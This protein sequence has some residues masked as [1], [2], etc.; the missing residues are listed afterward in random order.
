MR[1]INYLLSIIFVAMLIGAFA[2]GG[3]LN[4]FLVDSNETFQAYIEGIKY[5]VSSGNNDDL[6]GSITFIFDESIDV[7]GDIKIYRSKNSFDDAYRNGKGVTF[8]NGSE[9]SNGEYFFVAEIMTSVGGKYI[10]PKQVEIIAGE[11]VDLALSLEDSLKFSNL[12]RISI[13]D[14]PTIGYYLVGSKF[15]VDGIIATLTFD[16]MTIDVT[17]EEFQTYG[18]NTLLKD[19]NGEFTPIEIGQT[20]TENEIAKSLYLVNRD[21]SAECFVE[22]MK[23]SKDIE[24][25]GDYGAF[26]TKETSTDNLITKEAKSTFDYFWNTANSDL[27]SEGYG[28]VPSFATNTYNGTTTTTESLGFSLIS[29]IIGIENGWVDKYTAYERVAGTLSTIENLNTYLGIFYSEIDINTGKPV[30]D[31]VVSVTDSAQL[32]TCVLITGNYFGG[33]IEEKANEIYRNAKW[34]SFY[35]SEDSMFFYD[36]YTSRNGFYN[37]LE[38]YEGQLLVYILS[39]ASI[40]GSLGYNAYYTMERHLGK[41]GKY[42][43][44][45]HTWDGSLAGHLYPQAFVN[46]DGLVDQKGVNWYKNSVIATYTSKEFTDSKS[47][48]YPT[49]QI[50]WGLSA[51]DMKKGYFTNHGSTPSGYTNNIHIYDGTIPVYAALSS[52]NFYPEASVIA[53]RNYSELDY[54]EGDYGFYS[55]F[56]TKG[57][58]TT[59][60]YNAVEKGLTITMFANYKNG[61]IWDLALKT[62]EIVKG[63]NKLGFQQYEY[64]AVT[65][66]TIL[67]PIGEQKDVITEAVVIE[68]SENLE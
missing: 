42:D 54:L 13:R 35:S 25:Q 58:W 33:D 28:L 59:G 60:S 34:K 10:I 30:G 3:E 16:E 2:M 12:K 6:R 55:A 7:D 32:L 27:S 39:E 15:S 1:F 66:A 45:I 20:V 37:M 14:L 9:I 44:F 22:E 46:F 57:S 48:E 43:E 31:K 4:E 49:Y 24:H 52:I 65:S 18:V 19:E 8:I 47:E 21:K 56:D 11:D 50:G 61:M 63:L 38:K 23:V 53:L 36:E 67:L 29:I 17:Q 68:E 41:L 40:D 26:F 5:S 64:D 51:S 62:P